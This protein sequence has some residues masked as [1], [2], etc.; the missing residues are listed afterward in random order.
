MQQ[1]N[2]TCQQRTSGLVSLYLEYH[3]SGAYIC[4]NFKPDALNVVYHRNF[5]AVFLKRIFV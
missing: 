2:K 3:D 4:T 1:Y 5:L